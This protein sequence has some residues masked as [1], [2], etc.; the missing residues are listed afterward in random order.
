MNIRI[1]KT[2]F[3]FLPSEI[4][5]MQQETAKIFGGG[6]NWGNPKNFHILYIS[7]VTN[8]KGKNYIE[9][10]HFMVL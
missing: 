2:T 9:T 4:H 7:I 1:I 8:Q 10:V 3:H 5:E 6:E